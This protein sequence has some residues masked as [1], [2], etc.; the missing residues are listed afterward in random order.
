MEGAGQLVRS[1]FGLHRLMH[2][3]QLDKSPREG[4]LPRA[5]K[6]VMVAALYF[7][8]ARF[9]LSLAQIHTNVSAVWPPTG[10]AIAAV[11]LLGQ[12]IWPGVLAG[13][14]L[15]NVLTPVPV[16]AAAAI[17]AGNTAEALIAGLL[18]RRLKFHP[19]L[20]RARDV[21]SL[22]LVAALATTV[23]ATIGNLSLCIE[24]AASWDAFGPL[25]LTWWLGDLAGAVTVAPVLLS[26]G[27]RGDDVLRGRRYIEAAVLLLLLS[28][29]ATVT[30]S[31]PGAPPAR[32]YPLT[33][34]L[35]PFM[36]WAGFRL[37]PRGVA[38]AIL[39]VSGF[40]VWGTTN[41]VGPFVGLSANDSLLVLQVFLGS[42]ALTF[43]LLA[44][45]MQER[46]VSERRLRENEKRLIGNL[47]IAGILARSPR[48]DDAMPRILQ[49][50]AEML[51][52]QV[53]A[54]WCPNNENATLECLTVWHSPRVTVERFRSATLASKFAPGV[55]L[56]GR[57]WSKPEPTWI[58]DVVIDN[59][60][61]R[62][63]IAAA[64]GL[65]SAVG[66]PIISGDRFLGVMEFFSAEIREPD[67]IVLGMFDSIGSQIGQFMERKRAEEALLAK[68]VE[69]QLVA[70]TTPVLLT[71]CSREL[72]YVF[73]NR[74]YAAMLGRQP[75]EIVGQP[76]VEI[77]GEEAFSSIKPHIDRVLG[78]ERVEYER[79]LAYKDLGPRFMRAAYIPDRDEH[80]QVVGWIASL[81]DIT[82][83]R[84]TKA[85]LAKSEQQLS[86]FFENATIAIHWVGPDGTI[87]RAN[88]C[89]LEMMG[90]E[91]N[92]YVGR[93]I[94]E[95]H[96]DQRVVADIL[97][98]LAAGDALERIPAQVRRK[99]GAIRDVLIDSSAYF[100]DGRFIHARFFS[101]DVTEQK[102]AEKTLIR[103]ASIVESTDDAVVGADLDGTI[104]SWNRGAERLY[105]Y[106]AD[107]VIGKSV[108]L[109]LPDD[110]QD[111]E[112]A[113]ME[114]LRRGETTEHYETVRRAKNG[115]NI[116]VSLTV[117]AIRD[118]AGQIVGASKI[119]R[120][121][122]ERKRA[123]EERERLLVSE[124]AARAD[125]EVANRAKDEFL[126]TLS[127]ELRTPLNAI[128]GW[129]TML[130][131]DKL[132]ADTQKRAI[133][134]IDRNARVQAQMIEG[135]LDV[136]RIVS[137]KF[138]LE[139]RP[140]QLS[141]VIQAA[142]ESIRPA[143][144]SKR[145]Q[146]LL[147]FDSSVGPVCGDFNRLQQ[148]VWNLVSNAV[149]FTPSGG[150]ISVQLRKRVSCAEIVVR[151]TGEGIEPQFL[152]HVFERFR[153]A[154]GSTTRR[155][156]GLGL[157]LAIVRHLVELHGGVARVESAGRGTGATFRVELP[158]ITAGD[159]DE[160]I[161]LIEPTHSQ[162]A[163][164][165]TLRGVRILVVDDEADTR[166]LLTELLT[167]LNAEVK[168]P[169]SAAEALSILRQWQPDVL[170]SDL[171]M[172]DVDGYAFLK[173]VR[174]IDQCGKIPA[175][176]LTA[177]ARER[178][179]ERALAAG[180]QLHLSK[181]VDINELTRAIELIL[182]AGP[183][184][185]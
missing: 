70:D 144:D 46:R 136:S 176:A 9:G 151:D 138:Q 163:S 120:D 85:A 57:I 30:F 170:V 73:V 134:I 185:D 1:R 94:A 177:Q 93:N 113:I 20:D 31:H 127:H 184:R 51:D 61:P 111:E 77:I 182:L 44:S 104:T 47:A 123:E 23:S 18:L 100:E 162:H 149:K 156:G 101:Q 119:A 81:D 64:D 124:Q 147:A 108:S 69:L 6:L 79:E 53:G 54:L 175:I 137:G 21:L 24:R 90:Y 98:R 158:I 86:D 121:I 3:D 129:A 42:N 154:D 139:L 148:V 109:L 50:M 29:S 96:V 178:D 125:A 82:E 179:Q 128:M 99:D 132:D 25:W 40:A 88:R 72:R 161:Q 4:L 33:R 102:I 5:T 32:Y 71:R 66:Y 105:G 41:D 83:R 107:E 11:L 38:L 27:T 16:A 10:I 62:A 75:E 35:V 155:H 22:V 135:V 150:E 140:V 143:A 166:D 76:I 117:S 34:L 91:L 84:R 159:T 59:N 14:F 181:P 131:G 68:E 28:V 55:G 19:A 183:S 133:E 118:A 52:W 26:W 43:L 172:P 48:L 110:R 103:L 169:D 122:T 63:P 78:G 106:R 65:H 114:K 116:H 130:R 180:F 126:A 112:P 13:A 157:G 173:Q 49:T 37:G 67:A 74:A 7:L 39:V 15:V 87:I 174:A 164:S 142:V 60:F 152:P 8:A 165:G 141:A 97:T 146:V 168:A 80:G 95:S 2:E 167:R 89:E 45:V 36:L 153:Q 145:L 171:A 160:S 115:R 56:P 12:R 58:K 17:A 92:E